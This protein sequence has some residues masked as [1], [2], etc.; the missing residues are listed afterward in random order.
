M[1]DKTLREL[2]FDILAAIYDTTEIELTEV[3]LG[4]ENDI[5]FNYRER[6]YYWLYVDEKDSKTAELCT[7]YPAD[8]KDNDEELNI[9]AHTARTRLRAQNVL[10]TTET[11][12]N[13]SSAQ[14]GETAVAVV[15]QENEDNYLYPYTYTLGGTSGGYYKSKNGP[16]RC[17]EKELPIT[18]CY[19]VR[20]V[21]DFYAKK[22]VK[23]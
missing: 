22:I 2:Y 4:K 18:H 1:A 12:L 14:K 15:T 7:H 21:R 16:W 17:D 6:D 13:W 3:E 11:V 19:P 20:P 5:Q 23:E 8:F 9:F 10:Q